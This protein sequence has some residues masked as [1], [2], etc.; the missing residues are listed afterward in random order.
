MLNNNQL[1]RF[2][3]IINMDAKIFDI[4]TISNI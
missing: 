2:N 3:V 4:K 1:M